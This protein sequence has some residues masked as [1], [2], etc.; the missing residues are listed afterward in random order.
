MVWPVKYGLWFFT[1]LVTILYNPV[2]VDFFFIVDVFD[3][4]II[5]YCTSWIALWETSH[6]SGFDIQHLTVTYWI[7]YL[8]IVFWEISHS[9]RWM[10]TCYVIQ[11]S[12]C[13]LDDYSCGFIIWA[14]PSSLALLYCKFN[15]CINFA[16]MLVLVFQKVNNTE[17]FSFFSQETGCMQE[18]KDSSKKFRSIFTSKL[19]M[20]SYSNLH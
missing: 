5:F 1:F 10:C 12:P 15:V 14:A 2:N 6:S 18:Q 20:F 7:F 17:C 19:L 13:G 8:W 9:I 11:L 3:Y 16:F 4:D